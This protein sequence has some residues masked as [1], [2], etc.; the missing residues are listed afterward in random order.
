[1]MHNLHTA[2]SV[3][4]YVVITGKARRSKKNK[5]RRRLRQIFIIKGAGR[6]R[7]K[8]GIPHGSLWR[9]GEKLQMYIFGGRKSQW[10]KI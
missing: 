3:I 9:D 2:K 10:I 5:R 8:T 7:I 1:M 4:G 6:P